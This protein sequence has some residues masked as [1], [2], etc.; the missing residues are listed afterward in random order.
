MRSAYHPDLSFLYRPDSPESVGSAM[1]SASQNPQF[2]GRA[3]RSRQSSTHP[4]P[5]VE[6]AQHP[7][8]RDPRTYRLS[9]LA[10]EVQE[11]E[12]L[13]LEKRNLSQSYS[14]QQSFPALWISWPKQ[15]II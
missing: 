9:A 13:R 4:V 12:K 6:R 7:L 1:T 3:D 14:S 11:S 10:S 2:E 15:R 8:Q 5:A